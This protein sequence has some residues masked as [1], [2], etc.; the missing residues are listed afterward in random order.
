M[1]D[2][3]HGIVDYT[4]PFV[5]DR[6][7]R[8]E[9]DWKR[10]QVDEALQRLRNFPAL[11]LEALLRCRQPGFVNPVS[12]ILTDHIRK[13][14]VGRKTSVAVRSLA[15]IPSNH[16]SSQSRD[17]SPGVSQRYW[18]A[19]HA[20]ALKAEADLAQSGVS[21]HIAWKAPVREDDRNEQAR[22]VEGFIKQGVQGIVLAPFDSRTLVGPVEAAAH[23]GIPTVV[24]DSALETPHI[25][26]F[27]ATDNKRGGALAADRLGELLGGS[28]TVLLLRY[29]EGSASTEEREKGFAQRLRQAFPNIKI[30]LS[31][32]FAGATRDSAK[33][34]AGSL[35]SQYGDD[36]RGVFTPNESSTAGM[37]MALSAVQKA[38]R[39]ILVGF[40]SSDVYVDSLRHKQ[41][42]G[43]VVQDPFRMGELGVKTLVDHLTGKSV[44]KRV[45]TGATMVTLE[46][47]DRPE[48][49]K[50][51][52]LPVQGI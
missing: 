26:S 40:D 13:P 35:L 50:L 49:Q 11:L 47:M 2:L 18:K 8:S 28:G 10:L 24:V 52:R 15:E 16:A 25:V 1:D 3:L 4:V 39:I 42:H 44:P 19:I 14:K 20:G 6:G 36:L 22:I 29:Q 43:L 37:L 45:D 32:E 17:Y 34:A 33:R 48:I 41:L 38:G 27:I 7:T 31:A 23:A 46:N 9:P 21:V 12:S 5:A 51:L 30:I